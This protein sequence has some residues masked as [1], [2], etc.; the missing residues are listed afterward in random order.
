MN[1]SIRKQAISGTVS[2]LTAL[3]IV[4]MVPTPSSAQV[5]VDSQ[6]SGVQM[7]TAADIYAYWTKERMAAA[8]PVTGLVANS[9]SAAQAQFAA[10]ALT[11]APGA[12]AGALPGKPQLAAAAIQA[13]GE[14]GIEPLAVPYHTFSPFTRWQY[15]AKYTK[16][17]IT[18]IG[19][20]FFTNN[21][22]NYVCSGSVIYTN[23][24]WTA[25]HCTSNTDFTHQFDTNFLFCPQ[26]DNGTTPMGCWASVN[27]WTWPAW[28]TN[29]SFEWDMGAAVMSNCGTVFCTDISNVTGYLGF[30]WNQGYEQHWVHFGYPQGSPFNGNKIQVCASEFGYQDSDGNNQGGPNSAE[31]GCDQTGGSS[32][33]PWL[34]SFGL[35]GQIGG[36]GGNYVN[37]HQDWLHTAFPFEINTP[38]FDSRACTL[39]EAAGRPLGSC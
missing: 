39:A 15:F 28:I 6:S 14:N 26:Y 35:P 9:A 20:V 25:G 10:S 17:P 2:L 19:K 5:P 36:G 11:G 3:C 38:Y 18:T 7:Q 34:I 1:D 24:V 37:G 8:R 21:G 32:G 30:A 29:N 27:L 23:I 31:S 16:Y 33:G 13:S 12:S 4:T 22:G